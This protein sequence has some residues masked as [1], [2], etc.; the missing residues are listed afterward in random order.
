M[1]DHQIGMAVIF[2]IAL[3]WIIISKKRKAARF[4]DVVEIIDVRPQRKKPRMLV[5]ILI[6]A[7]IIAFIWMM[8]H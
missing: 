1:T 4:I 2:G 7:G 3:T 5:N 8:N 6:V